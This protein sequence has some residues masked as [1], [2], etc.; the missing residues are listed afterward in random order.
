MIS[1]L[2]VDDQA[3]IRLL[4][5]TLITTANDGLEC[6]IE[7]ESGEAAIAYLDAGDATVIVLDQMMPGMTGV[8]TAQLI[9]GRHPDQRI[10]LFSAYLD[11]QLRTEAHSLGIREC[12]DKRN[13]DHVVPAV[14]RV[15][16]A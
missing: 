4:V 6:N 8:E 11:A 15:A 3:D 14:R 16:A 1:V 10:I 2:V 9:L 12:I 13:F 7:A 5:R